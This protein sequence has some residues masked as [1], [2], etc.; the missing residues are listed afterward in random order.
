MTIDTVA[1]SKRRFCGSVRFATDA[2]TTGAESGLFASVPIG[3]EMQRDQQASLRRLTI[4][5]PTV[6]SEK[7]FWGL[8][9]HAWNEAVHVVDFIEPEGQD[10][11]AIDWGATEDE[12]T[13]IYNIVTRLRDLLVQPQGDP[14]RGV[15]AIEPLRDVIFAEQMEVQ[16]AGLP[17]WQPVISI[18]RRTAE[19]N[20]E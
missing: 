12:P 10:D 16:I 20:D 14:P 3:S 8:Q 5:Q 9:T 2:T 19:A 13:S 4:R 7:T 15:I 18:D 11:F 6:A 1:L 17:R